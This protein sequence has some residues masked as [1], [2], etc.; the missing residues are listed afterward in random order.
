[1]P[2]LK[3]KDIR[4]DGETQPRKY[5]NEEVVGDYAELL[6]EDA[7]FPPVTVFNDGANY[8][9]ADG[10]HRFHANKKAGFLDIEANVIDGTRREA[11]LFS[12]GANAVHGLRRTNEDKRKA[13]E[14][15]LN[16]IEW[17]EWS[18]RE[19]A[20]Q[21]NVSDM[22]VSRVRKTLGLA[23]TEKKYST[24]H[25]TQATMK[26]DNM[27][28]PS[29]PVVMMPPAESEANHELEELAAAHAE[30]AEENAKLLDKLAVATMD[31]TEEEK[32]AAANTLEE[33]RMQVK[34]LEAELRAVKS[35]RDQLQA[36]NAD[37]LK[38]IKYWQKRAEKAEKL[39]EKE[40]A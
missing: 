24:K 7:T 33:L 9:L 38:Q 1:M 26:T 13:V 20:R 18:D 40:A 6:L 2:R 32:A 35:S 4:L 11:I 16:D 37:M 23:K 10:F 28:K 36:K 14:T 12:V 31:A 34:T 3:L 29:E 17:S 25:G 21:C 30:L 22:T 19:I 27:K 8:W 15:L 5:V 39:I